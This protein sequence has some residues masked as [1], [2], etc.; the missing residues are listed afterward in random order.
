M[1]EKLLNCICIGTGANQN[2]V[3]IY[4]FLQF[5]LIYK[6]VCNISNLLHLGVPT[7]IGWLII[8]VVERWTL[9]R[10]SLAHSIYYVCICAHTFP[11]FC[12]TCAY[13]WI[14]GRVHLYCEYTHTNKYLYT[15]TYGY[16]HLIWQGH[17]FGI[18]LDWNALYQ[19][20]RR[21]YVKENSNAVSQ[22]YGKSKYLKQIANQFIY[23]LCMFVLF[24]SFYWT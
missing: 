19:F 17:D 5:T 1:L 24:A 12:C 20:D 23:T 18:E 16:I 6:I 10:R 2:T 9:R 11:Y 14:L 22:K 13:V 3:F 7:F 15:H 8:V 4:L 21:Q